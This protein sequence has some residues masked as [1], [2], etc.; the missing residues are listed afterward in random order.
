MNRK[1]KVKLLKKV[2]RDNFKA[3]FIIILPILIFVLTL[4][5]IGII[6]LLENPI[7]SA[8]YFGTFLVGAAYIGVSIMVLYATKKYFMNCIEY[9]IKLKMFIKYHEHYSIYK[10]DEFIKLENKYNKYFYAKI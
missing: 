3:S 10:I 6:T 1:K 4:F 5:V 8:I 2:Y 9:W 7:S